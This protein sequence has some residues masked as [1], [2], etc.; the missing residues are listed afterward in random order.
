MADNQASAMMAY[1]TDELRKLGVPEANLRAAAAHLTGQAEMESGFNPNATH[2]GGTG[3][4]I[5][6]AGRDRRDQMLGWLKTNNYAPNSLEG[7]TRYMA[8][9]ALKYPKTRDIL[10]N[11]NE[12]NLAKDSRGITADFERPAVINDRSGAVL[13]A[14]YGGG[15][16]PTPA[17]DAG[18][19]GAAAGQSVASSLLPFGSSTQSAALL[20]ANTQPK[21]TPPDTKTALSQRLLDLVSAM[22]PKEQPIASTPI[23]M[24]QTQLLRPITFQQNGAQNG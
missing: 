10:L 22:Q 7:Q 17:P 12:N 18:A 2:D 15:A 6:G 13:R 1:A 24:P 21:A 23:Q 9:E 3:Y 4:G 5:Y 14:F 16:T 19:I 11:A 20:G 8:N